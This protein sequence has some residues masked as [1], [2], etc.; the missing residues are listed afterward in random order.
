LTSLASLALT[1]AAVRKAL[2]VAEAADLLNTESSSLVHKEISPS[3]LINTGMDYE[4]Q[5]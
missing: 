4:E 5:Q 3:I 2:A 1:Q